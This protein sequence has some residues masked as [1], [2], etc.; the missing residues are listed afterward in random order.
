MVEAFLEHFVHERNTHMGTGEPVLLVEPDADRRR[1]YLQAL[2][3]AGYTVYSAGDCSTA[4]S[5][6]KEQGTCAVITER[7]LPDGQGDILIQYVIGCQ[8]AECTILMGH[9]PDLV[10]AA[11]QCGADVSFDT[12]ESSTQLGHLLDTLFNEFLHLR[13]Q[14]NEG[15]EIGV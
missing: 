7:E 5:I 11:A 4:K 15:G 13:N 12:A 8:L 9:S 1:L 2:G 10:I 3:Q 6:L 14:R